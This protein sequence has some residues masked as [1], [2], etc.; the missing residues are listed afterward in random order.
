MLRREA[1]PGRSISSRLRAAGLGLVPSV[2][3]LGGCLVRFHFDPPPRLP[4]ARNQ[5]QACVYR[6]AILVAG[7]KAKWEESE[8]EGRWLVTYRYW[9]GGLTFYR[10]GRR[11]NAAQVARIVREPHFSSEYLEDL[12]R[13]KRRVRIF[14]AWSVVTEVLVGASLVGIGVLA[15]RVDTVDEDVGLWTLVGLV[16]FATVGSLLDV[17]YL[18]KSWRRSKQAYLVRK[19]IVVDKK[20]LRDLLAALESYNKAVVARCAQQY[21]MG[22]IQLPRGL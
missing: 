18:R 6:N 1:K 14:S 21:G 7:A 20:Y 9:K 19:T 12:Q 5:F 17:L 3:V 4:P 10:G 13:R 22:L 2:L 8:S 11:L 15:S 16:S